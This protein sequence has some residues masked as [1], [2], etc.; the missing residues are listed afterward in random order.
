MIDV[1][2]EIQYI[3]VSRLLSGMAQE[4]FLTADEL[5]RM[6]QGSAGGGA[7]DPP[8]VPEAGDG[9]MAGPAAHRSH[10]LWRRRHP[11]T[12]GQDHRSGRGDDPGEAEGRGRENR[13]ENVIN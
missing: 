2:N 11:Q 4:G 8:G 1:K 7:A 13:A 5:A 3:I 6:A 10:R 12:G 9:G